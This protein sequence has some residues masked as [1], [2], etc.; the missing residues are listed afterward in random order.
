MFLQTTTPDTSGYMIAGY[1]V[2]FVVMGLYVA[3]MYLRSRNLQQD[4]TTLEEMDK[5]ASA[6]A[7]PAKKK[8]KSVT[9]KSV[10]R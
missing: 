7:G 2:A 6:Q 4:L 10:K 8:S 9:K 3:S 1:V 5:A